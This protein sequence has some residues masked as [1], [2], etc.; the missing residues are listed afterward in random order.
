MT[1]KARQSNQQ[2]YNSVNSISAASAEAADKMDQKVEQYLRSII[3]KAVIECGRRIDD[4][5]YLQ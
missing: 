2:A 1:I 3:A 4:M 5:S